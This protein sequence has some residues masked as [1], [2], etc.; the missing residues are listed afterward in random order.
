MVGPFPSLWGND[1][2]YT[3]LQAF[4]KNTVALQNIP[5]RGAVSNEERGVQL[6]L[7]NEVQQLAAA[8]GI[9]PSGLEDEVFSI[10]LRQGQRLWGLIHGNQYDD[11]VGAGNPPGGFKAGGRT[12][13]L[14][15][16]IRA[17]S[18]ALGTDFF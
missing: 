2:F 10:H 3:V 18:M 6:P 4:L 9:D 1:P 14:Y 11:G 5:K 12:G 15:H 17:A 16:G 7:L 8:A 13:G